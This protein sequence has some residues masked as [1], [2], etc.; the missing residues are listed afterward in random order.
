MEKPDTIRERLD[1]ALEAAGL[2]FWEN[3]LVSG[4]VIHKAT[5]IFSELGYSDEDAPYLVDDLLSLVHP[6]DIPVIKEAIE[7]HLQGRSA[8][9]RCEFRI[10]SKSG[11]W[12]WYANY[13]KVMDGDNQAGRRFIGVTFN[14]NDRKSQ[15][16]LLKRTN[17]AL[18]VISRCHRLIHNIDDENELLQEICRIIVENG[19]YRMA[20]VGFAQNDLE[21]TVEPMAYAGFEAGYLEKLHISWNDAED[22]DSPTGKAI[23][24]GEVMVIRGIANNPDADSWRSIALERG[25]SSAISIPL[26]IEGQSIGN[27]NIYS[28]EY[29]AFDSEEID[30]L[31]QLAADLSFGISHIRNKIKARITEETIEHLAHYD[32]LTDLPNR[33]LFSHY[34]QQALAISKRSNSR[35]AVMFIDVDNFKPINDKLGHDVG[36]LL[37]AEVAKRLRLSL[38]ESDIA[39]R[40]GGDEFLVLLP[41][42]ESD[43]D[44]RIVADKIADSLRLP[45]PIADN[46][47]RISASIGIAIYPDNGH[48]ENYLIRNAD[49]AMYKAKREETPVCFYAE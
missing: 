34:L 41:T 19:G 13:G 23:R 44:A 31:K 18:H 29:H 8:Q 37:L 38:R 26:R 6:Q 2:D 14:I 22:N 42:I 30:L 32:A 49:M 43:D 48:D 5:R 24:S 9:Y 17:R 3:D 39:A 47:I 35:F 21:K 20:W 1:L 33:T 27:L 12:V 11:D 40:F 36:D 16:E 28:D 45:F 25:F 4:T 7:Q 10:R 46:A 15:E